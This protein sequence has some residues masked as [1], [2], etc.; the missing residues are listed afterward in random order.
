VISITRPV[1]SNIYL[2]LFYI[3][4]QKKGKGKEIK[5]K[6]LIRGNE[7]IFQWI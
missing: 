3:E 1:L 5:V 4:E 6:M 2:N 7:E